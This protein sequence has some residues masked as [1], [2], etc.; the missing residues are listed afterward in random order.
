MACPDVEDHAAI[1]SHTCASKIERFAIGGDHGQELALHGM[2]D[3]Q[4]QLFDLCPHRTG[5]KKYRNDERCAHSLA[6]R[7]CTIFR[8][9][10]FSYLH[11]LRTEIRLPWPQR[12]SNARFRL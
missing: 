12:K 10:K 6:E 4:R 11:S 2:V 1:E 8:S 5:E 9:G 3:R 7:S